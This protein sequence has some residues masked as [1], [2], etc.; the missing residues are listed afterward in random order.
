[1]ACAM[2]WLSK[3]KS[4]EWRS[5]G[6]LASSVLLN[7]RRP[8]SLSQLKTRTRHGFV[9]HSLPVEFKYRTFY[10]ACERIQREIIRLGAE[11][12]GNFTRDRLQRNQGIGNKDRNQWRNDA[13]RV[14]QAEGQDFAPGLP[15][16]VLPNLTMW[17]SDRIAGPI[18][19]WNG[20]SYGGFFNIDE[21]YCFR[22]GAC[23]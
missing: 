23:G 4:S 10:R 22:Q 14:Y 18:G 8:V 1:M 2:I 16:Y 12:F 7:A 5:N 13:D 6:K 11:R 3:M 19:E 20:T 21:W 9:R 17:R 15:L